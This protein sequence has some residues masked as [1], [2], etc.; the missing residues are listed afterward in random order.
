MRMF[1]AQERRTFDV[2]LEMLKMELTHIDGAIRQHD[3]I[4]KS[5]KNWAIVTWT[6]SV[7]L[8]LKDPNL[9]GFVW[10]TAV[11]SIVFWFVDGSFRRIQRSFISRVRQISEFVNSED[12][13]VAA[14]NGAPMDF[15]LLFMRRKTGEFNNTQLGTMLFPSVSILYIGLA[16]CSLLVWF[17]LRS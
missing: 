16:V 13:K 15:P 8:A 12:F 17:L 4:T 6:A 1:M 3:E 14:D 7:G 11:V 9:H 5:V 2:Q 10:L